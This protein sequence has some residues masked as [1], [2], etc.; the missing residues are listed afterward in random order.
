VKFHAGVTGARKQ[1]KATGTPAVFVVPNNK[2]HVYVLFV[3]HA[4]RLAI[5]E[6]SKDGQVDED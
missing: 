4:K 6:A 3:R 2:R 1:L 5:G